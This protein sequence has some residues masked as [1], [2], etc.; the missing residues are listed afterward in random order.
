MAVKKGTTIFGFLDGITHKKKEWSSYIE[1]DKKKFSPFMVNRW[2]SMSMGL[3]E[4]VNE[5]QKYTIGLLSPRDTYRLYHGL[6]PDQKTFAKYI[7]SKKA[8]KYEKQLV[9]QVAEHYQVSKAEA[10]EYINLLDRD[11]CVNLLNKYGYTEK[12]IKSLLKGKK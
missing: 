11:S 8:D 7:K 5:L 2:L 3:I 6:L 10:I 1:T 4:V 9:S 12:E